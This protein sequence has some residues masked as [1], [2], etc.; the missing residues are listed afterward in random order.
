MSAFIVSKAHIDAI[1]DVAANG[2][3]GR[4]PQYPGD[5][6]YSTTWSEDGVRLSARPDSDLAGQMLWRE[7]YLSVT[8]RYPE[9]EGENALPGPCDFSVADVL[10]YT[11]TRPSARLTTVQC[12]KAIRC[13]EYQ[14]CEHP[15]WKDSPAYAFCQ[16]LTASLI[17]E[18]PG[19]DE[20]AWEI[21]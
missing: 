9:A 20:A 2:P 18:L 8:Y 15:G 21:D 10:T 6:W 12:L 1:V 17:A 3:S 5:G 19:Y 4:G 13:Y 14:S 7:C 16:H 11:F